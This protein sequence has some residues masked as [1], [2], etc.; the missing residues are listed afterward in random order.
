MSLRQAVLENNLEGVQNYLDDG[1]DP[2]YLDPSDECGALHFAAAI[3]N[4]DIL[5]ALLQHV[6]SAKSL[7]SSQSSAHWASWMTS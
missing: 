2:N 1:A 4:I 3:G 6:S 5:T 7:S